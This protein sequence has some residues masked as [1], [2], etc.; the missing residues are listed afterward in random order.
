MRIANLSLSSQNRLNIYLEGINSRYWI[1]ERCI[2]R[3]YSMFMF[4]IR[5]NCLLSKRL[6]LMMRAINRT[7]RSFLFR[8]GLGISN[9][10]MLMYD[11]K[12]GVQFLM[13]NLLQI[14]LLI[15]FVMTILVL[16]TSNCLLMLKI[17]CLIP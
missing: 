11:S 17:K 8:Y 15:V 10:M 7:N 9:V 4:H 5:Q 14:I 12:W 16:A 13:G 1:L 2:I 6:I 3:R